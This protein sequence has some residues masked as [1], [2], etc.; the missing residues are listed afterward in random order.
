[1][2]PGPSADFWEFELYV[3]DNTRRSLFAKENLAAFCDKYLEGDARID[4]F[5]L[6]RHPEIGFEKNICVTPTL[7]KIHPLPMRT[8]IGDLSDTGK[9][10]KFLDVAPQKYVPAGTT[11]Y[12]EGLRKQGLS[13]RVRHVAPGR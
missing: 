8:L 5:D 9:I 7:V 10:M 3:N 4:V 6:A 1:L 13:S 11:S 2:S 12:S